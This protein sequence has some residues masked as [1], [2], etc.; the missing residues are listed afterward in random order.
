MMQ[1]IIDKDNCT[2]CYA[3]FNICPTKAIDMIED[4]KG[5]KT[6]VINKDKCINCG[7]CKK[8]CPVINNKEENKDIEAFACMNKNENIRKESS[9]GGIFYLLAQYILEKKGVVFGASFDNNW[10]VEHTYIEKI[11][12]IKKFMGSKYVQSTIG[13]SYK[14]A[15]EFLENDRYVLFTGTPCQI[16]GLNKF[17]G[18]EYDKLYTQ[19]I[20]CHGVP[21]P[22]VWRKYLQFR[23]MKDKKIPININFRNKENG[24]Q[25]Y[26]IKFEY[27][28]NSYKMLANNDIYV[29][30]FLRNTI[31]RDSCYNCH[32]KKLYRLSDITLA[33]FWGV[34][35]VL[36]EMNDNKGTSLIIVNSKKGQTLIKEINEKIEM[37]GVDIKEAIKYNPSMIKSVDKDEKREDFFDNIDKIE[38]DEL[39]K[40]HTTGPKMIN[41]IKSKVKALIIYLMN[42]IKR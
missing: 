28:R 4:K 14:K 11:E 15:K 20:I 8:V 42:K 39:V 2:G 5:F 29:Q 37:K 30:S 41:K 32:F 1:K 7:M 12:D 6:Y 22:K 34:K 18:K 23:K 17:L 13:D 3:C 25:N 9:S 10:E 16:E 40:K 31:L 36:P 38:F 35:Q 33:D 21:S 26:N 24:W 27:E 19:D